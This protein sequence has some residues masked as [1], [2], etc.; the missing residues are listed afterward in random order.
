MIIK[1]NFNEKLLNLFAPRQL[2]VFLSSEYQVKYSIEQNYLAFKIC[3][4]PNKYTIVKIK[5]LLYNV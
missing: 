1:M 5:Y 3:Y 4:N 2:S